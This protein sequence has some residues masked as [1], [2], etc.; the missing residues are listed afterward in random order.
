MF[1]FQYRSYGLL[2]DA[3][4][5]L[6]EMHLGIVCVQAIGLWGATGC[7]CLVLENAF[8]MFLCSMALFCLCMRKFQKRAPKT[9]ERTAGNVS[10][11]TQGSIA[12]NVSNQAAKDDMLQTW[13]CTFLRFPG[14]DV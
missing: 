6:L 9:W 12:Q 3:F 2:L 10:F 7:V 8:G 13:A 14:R 11:K 1:V 5:S 4:L